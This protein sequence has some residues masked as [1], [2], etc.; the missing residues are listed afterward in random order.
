MRVHVSNTLNDLASD[1]RKIATG[2]RRD[3]REVVLISARD[4]NAIARGFAKKSAG[5]HGKHYFKAFTA[6]ASQTREFGGVG[7]I[8]AE[9]GPRIDRPQGGMSFERGSRNSP[10]HNDLA[11]SADLIAPFFDI[12][13]QELPDKWFWPNG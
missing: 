8:S 12:A 4:G 7:V 1:L 2:A 13:A 11:K 9:Y 6:E 3:M 10:P 5:S